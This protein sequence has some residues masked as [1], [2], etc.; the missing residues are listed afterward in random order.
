M[1][2]TNIEY[3]NNYL[4]LF[5][6]N[7]KNSFEEYGEVIDK[8]YKDLIESET[9]N[10][11]KY[12]KRFTNKMKKYKKQVA[13]KD[14]SIFNNEIYI[15]KNINFK[16]IWISGELSDNNKEKIWEYLQTLFILSE[17]IIN[18]ANTIKNLIKSF[19]KINDNGL[20]NVEKE[21]NSDEN[22]TEKSE[23]DENKEA[24]DNQDT[25][26]ELLNMIKNL[27][28]DKEDKTE[29]DEKFIE[30]GLIGKLA[31][32]LTEELNLDDIDLNLKESKNVNDIFSNLMNGDNSLKFMN[33]IQTVG[34]KIQNKVQ[35]G[36]FNQ[37]D[38]FS[39]AK[40]V[41]STLQDKNNIFE[42][43]MK[44]EN[45]QSLNKTH[46]RLKNKLKKK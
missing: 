11:D 36:E 46:E 40:K 8:Y 9:C 33:L 2:K 21:S 31:S 1:E 10:D 25:D 4:K 18:D 24:G 16:D 39:E 27:S 45:D 26:D 13:E 43:L 44:T 42:Q 37:N 29:I 15:L 7:I 35:N 6:I 20:E 19:K 3:F 28:S 5:I 14:D 34:N 12:V 23:S 22:E 30:E 32:E 41:M 17:T 38:L